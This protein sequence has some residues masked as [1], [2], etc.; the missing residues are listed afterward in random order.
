MIILTITLFSLAAILGLV[1]L[2]RLLS[3]KPLNRPVV[4]AH[5]L[6][7]ATGL[8]MLIYYSIQNSDH[9]PKFSIIIFVI[10]ALGGF[11]LF[12]NDFRKKPGPV[13][14]AIIHAAAAVIAFLLLIVFVLS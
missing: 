10:A 11:V 5:G 4:Y 14:L 6:L 7:A 2:T 1:L 13:F 8:V 9:Y 3:K 12:I